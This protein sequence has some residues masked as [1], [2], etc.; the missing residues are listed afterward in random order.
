MTDA[1]C[2]GD[3]VRNALTRK[4]GDGT[5]RS[6]LHL[7]VDRRGLNIQRTAENEG[8]AEHI[9]DLIWVVAAPGGDDR[10]RAHGLGIFR[11]D[12]RNGIGHREDDRPVGHLLHPF[13]LQRT[14]TGQAKEYVGTFQ[15]F[16]E[17]GCRCLHRMGAL[18]LI[19]IVTS[20]SDRPGAITDDDVF[21]PDP[22]GL[23]QSGTGERAGPCPVDDHLAVFHF[24]PGQV[25]G[26]DQARGS[27]DR[28]AVLVVMHD[29]DIHAFAQRLLDNKAFGRGDVFEIDAAEGRFHQGDRLDKLVGIFGIEF[30]VDRI[31]V[32]KAFE[33]HRLAFHHRL[34]GQRTEIA[35]AQDRRAVRNNGNKVRTGRIAS[36]ILGIGRNR[37]H[38]SRHTGRISEAEITLARHGLACDD[39]DLTRTNCLVVEQSFACGECGFFVGHRRSLVLRGAAP[40]RLRQEV[41][42][43]RPHRR[44]PNR[45][46]PR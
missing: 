44:L 23:D 27:D 18:P 6:D 40:N 38:R 2:R 16:F 33:Q 26:V 20:R 22:H 10:I 31:H 29:R 15:R 39:L 11:H 3:L 37:F 13:R 1:I 8:E 4:F 12:F 36:R 43:E 21:M 46:H 32:G 9:V 42:G 7:F 24:P 34:R 17:I 45:G 25:A 19:D 28:G 5:G 35:E 14:C 41:I 30:D